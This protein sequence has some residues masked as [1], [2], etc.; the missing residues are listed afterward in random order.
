MLNAE[1][2]K[3][4]KAKGRQYVQTVDKLYSLAMQGPRVCAYRE[5]R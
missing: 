1:N 2:A 3:V 4:G 5:D